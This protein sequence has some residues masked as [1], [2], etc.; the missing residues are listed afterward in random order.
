MM[1]EGASI[2]TEVLVPCRADICGRDANLGCGG[3]GIDE[4]FWPKILL[5]PI[6]GGTIFILTELLFTG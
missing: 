2:L 4:I 1:L 5:E 6:V 3:L